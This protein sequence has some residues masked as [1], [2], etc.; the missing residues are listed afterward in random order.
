MEELAGLLSAS[1]ADLD[2]RLA[3]PDGGAAVAASG[4]AV[5][6]KCVR[7]CVRAWGRRGGVWMGEPKWWG[8]TD[9]SLPLVLVRYEMCRALSKAMLEL[10]GLL[11]A[12]DGLVTRV[13]GEQEAQAEALKSK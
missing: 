4:G 12:R 11:D 8:F 13:R 10:A 7:A 6:T 1:R 9:V 3:K 5:D 2:G